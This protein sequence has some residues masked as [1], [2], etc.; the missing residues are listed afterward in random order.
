MQRAQGVRAELRQRKS[1]H[2]VQHFER[3]NALAVRR[4]LIDRPAA[5][6]RRNGIDPLAFVFGEVVGGHRAAVQRR[7][8]DNLARN[9]SFIEGVPAMGRELAIGGCQIVVAKQ[10]AGNRHTAADEKCLRGWRVG[11]ERLLA[12]APV[13]ADHFAYGKS[14]FG[15][16]D[17]RS[18][19]IA[20]RLAS[21]SFQQL[22]PSVD[23]AGYRHRMNT[24]LRHRGDAF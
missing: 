19:Q 8:G 10:F 16:C 17:R 4:K 6:G 18:E 12:V 20:E 23:R 11:G 3:R 7:G 1:F 9:L 22:V 5:I 2:D 14:A 24:L 13:R 15:I 21:K